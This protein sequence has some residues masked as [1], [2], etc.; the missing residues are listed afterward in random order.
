LQ[1]IRTPFSGSLLILGAQRVLSVRSVELRRESGAQ[2]SN[3]KQ[4]FAGPVRVASCDDAHADYL[5]DVSCPSAQTRARGL[6]F[7]S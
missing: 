7:V 1:A 2:I 4:W 5:R 3:G 6:D